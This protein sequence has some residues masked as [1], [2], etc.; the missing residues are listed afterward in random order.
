[1]NKSA[2]RW[3]IVLMSVSLIG[4]LTFQFYWIDGV[5]KNNK[6]L[7]KR[8]VQDALSHVVDM[9]EKQEVL[10]F[11][12]D[13]FY[14]QFVLKS[15]SSD[16]PGQLELIEST[17]EKRIVEIEDVND[18]DKIDSI[19]SDHKFGL[20]FFYETDDRNLPLENVTIDIKDNIKTKKNK[21]LIFDEDTSKHSLKERTV[22]IQLKKVAK[23]S[24]YLQVAIHELVSGKKPIRARID[25]NQIDSLLQTS[26][27]DKGINIDY[28]FGV[29]D[30][31][32]QEM[33]IR[34]AN[35]NIS[36][37]NN[38]ELRVNMYP[39]DIIGEAGFLLID[40]PEQQAFLLK[41][42][43]FTLASSVILILVIVFCFGYAIF[44]IFRQKKLSDIKNDF[45]NNMTHE[46]KT[47][48]ST[49]S[50]ACEALQDE[51]IS[52]TKGLKERY[53]KIISDENKRL[54]MQV[55]KVLQMAVIERK[56]FDLKLEK[57]NLHDII[58]KALGNIAIQVNNKGGIISK[59]LRAVKQ[60]IN[61]DQMHL[62]NIVYNLLDNANKYS[63]ETP[64]IKI[65]TEDNSKGIVINII[66]K[67]I[68]MS[69]DA[70]SK[71]FEKFYRVPTGNLHDV[72]G[73]GL[74][75]A[76]VKNMVEA[77]GGVI[78][79]K[80][81]LNKGSNFKIFLPFTPTT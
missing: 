54:G 44:T 71:I 48:I 64:N 63:P 59:D 65:S 6:E 42:I 5:I 69:K 27:M 81:E 41:K 79:V 28:Q 21:I 68:G 73:F 9:L 52:A 4:L 19:S 17:F 58:D 32:N 11:A 37:L 2:I 76:Y 14:T 51:Q 77:H 31:S 26:L 3:I 39:N 33:F 78:N 70:I 50:L 43:W 61:A 62:T 15:H 13:N 47:P 18:V 55:E 24:E 57:V 25:S 23:K 7:F 10:H 38:T 22:E 53:L 56:D 29:I 36:N 80:S 16:N 30:A 46:F 67:G 45:I 49:V 12:E 75:L 20:S 8:D 66:D 74:G 60:L 72:K 34:K 40:F 1:M 35:Y